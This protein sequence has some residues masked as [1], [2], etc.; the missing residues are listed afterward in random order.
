MTI[1]RLEVDW[2]VWI[3]TNLP[4]KGVLIVTPTSSDDTFHYRLVINTWLD[5]TSRILIM[6]LRHQRSFTVRDH[7]AFPPTFQPVLDY[8]IGN[9]TFP[10]GEKGVVVT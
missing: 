4:G 1:S 6:P 10:V 9:E 2:C 7:H 3:N 8:R 5:S